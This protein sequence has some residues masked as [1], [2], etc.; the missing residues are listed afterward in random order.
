[1]SERGVYDP[2]WLQKVFERNRA[3]INELPE[4]AQIRYGFK[5]PQ[6]RLVWV[7]EFGT[8]V[9]DAEQEATS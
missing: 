3:E 1:M 6:L 8:I 9:R 5:R 2:G 4:S 7:D